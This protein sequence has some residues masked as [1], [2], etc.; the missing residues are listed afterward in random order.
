MVV[1]LDKKNNILIKLVGFGNA[2]RIGAP[3]IS[4]A[5]GHNSI[6]NAPEA[7]NEQEADKQDIWGC[8]VIFLE[9]LSGERNFPNFIENRR[10]I[11]QEIV[12]RQPLSAEQK[13]LYV[14]LIG[15][16]LEV[17]PGKRV[18]ASGA[19][20]H[21]IFGLREEPESGGKKAQVVLKGLLHYRVLML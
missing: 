1:R 14:D 17:S 8:G 6:F 11:V 10:R 18:S 2:H 4:S 15:K 3:T 7:E 16:M 5:I 20:E 21:P 19:L 12:E 9:L 13:E